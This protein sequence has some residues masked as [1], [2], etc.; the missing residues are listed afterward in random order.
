MEHHEVQESESQRGNRESYG[1]EC[2]KHQRLEVPVSDR[3]CVKADEEY[4]ESSS[5]GR[6]V[7]DIPQEHG[8]LNVP[9]EQ[10]ELHNEQHQQNGEG[11]SS[12]DPQGVEKYRTNNAE[13]DQLRCP[14]I[15]IKDP[16]LK[17]DQTDYEATHDRHQ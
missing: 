10:P 2:G 12:I 8:K 9:Q 14:E 13:H 7:N 17:Y 15:W 3:L 4:I 5:E 1:K 11:I 16:P 6:K